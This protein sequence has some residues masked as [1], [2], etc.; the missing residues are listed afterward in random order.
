MTALHFASRYGNADIVECLLVAGANVNSM[1]DYGKTALHWAANHGEPATTLAL[2]IAGSDPS[3]KNRFGSTPISLAA[4]AGH[5]AVV[6]LLLSYGSPIPLTK[7]DPG[8]LPPGIPDYS[9]AVVAAFQEARGKT[10]EELATSRA[11]IA[12]FEMYERAAKLV[13]EGEYRRM[14]DAD[15]QRKKDEAKAADGL[16]VSRSNNP[17]AG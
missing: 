3:A 12:N 5:L 7:A 8:P 4:H 9:D 1:D 15:E 10:Q 2:L 14:Q 11:R 6:Q 17:S 13:L 16:Y